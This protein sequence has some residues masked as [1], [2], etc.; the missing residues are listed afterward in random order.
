MGVETLDEQH[1]HFFELANAVY[2]LLEKQNLD[3]AK[4]ETAV[5][6]MANYAMYH[7]SAEEEL[8]EQF[9][10]PKAAEHVQMHDVYRIEVK[11]LFAQTRVVDESGLAEVTRRVVDFSTE[12]LRSHILKV[13][14]EYS[15][16]FKE[17]GIV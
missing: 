6:E 15:V 13:D 2:D 3:R 10:Y 5:S 11:Q 12:W 14:K 16:F 1:Q 9:N 8:F 7:L 17:K 4:L